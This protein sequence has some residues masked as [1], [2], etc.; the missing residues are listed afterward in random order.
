[1]SKHY[2]SIAFTDDV[3]EAQ[4]RYGSGDFYA[5]QQ[6]AGGTSGEPDPLTATERDFLAGRDSF[7]LATI[8]ASGWPTSSTAAAPLAFS[9]SSMSTPWGGPTSAET[10]STSPPATLPAP[11]GWRS[12]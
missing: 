10:C 7:Y 8:S 12:S 4:A 9:G 1:M 5:R 3:A 6:A 11:T 2:G